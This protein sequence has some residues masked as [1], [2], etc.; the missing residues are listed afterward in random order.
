LKVEFYGEL[1]VDG[2]NVVNRNFIEF[3]GELFGDLGVEGKLLRTG[4]L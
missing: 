2:W 1:G 3:V 4:I